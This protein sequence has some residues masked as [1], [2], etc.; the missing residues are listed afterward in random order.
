MRSAPALPST[1][2]WT[3]TSMLS[4]TGLAEEMQ[5]PGRLVGTHFFRP[6]TAHEAG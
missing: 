6:G 1:P 2:I 4:I 5:H 3:N